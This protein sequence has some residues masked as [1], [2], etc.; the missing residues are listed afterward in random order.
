M[1]QQLDSS[2]LD[3]ELILVNDGSNDESYSLVR[4]AAAGVSRIKLVTYEKNQGRGYA[5]WRGIQVAGGDVVVTTEVDLS[6]GDT[7][8]SDIV[9][10]FSRNPLLDAVIASPNLPG[11]CYKNVPLRRVWI[12]RVG[13]QLLR[14]LFSPKITMYTGMTR[15]YRRELIQGFACDELGKEFHLDVVFKLI[16]LKCYIEEVP[17]I[18]EWKDA[19]LTQNA[20]AK[21]KS[22]TKILKLISSHLNFAAFANPIRYFWASSVI[23]GICGLVLGMTALLG[24]YSYQSNIY[25]AILAVLLEIF[26]LLLLGFGVI[27]SQNNRILRELWRTQMMH[28]SGDDIG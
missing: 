18:L 27:S 21:R 22:S 10:K 6:W 26:A 14:V 25:F 12:S 11:G 19:K 1:L 28:R 7:I 24:I 23:S 5:L 3:W 2:G 16:L 9:E 15:G 13:N 8:V 20:G 17:A 4:A